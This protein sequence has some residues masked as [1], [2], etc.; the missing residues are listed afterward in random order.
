MVRGGEDGE[1]EGDGGEEGDA[2]S[3]LKGSSSRSHSPNGRGV[4]A[5]G[6]DRRPPSLY[7]ARSSK[8]GWGV[9]D[10]D[11][12]FRLGG[13]EKGV[14]V[15]GV[16]RAAKKASSS[17]LSP[18]ELRESRG[19]QRRRRRCHC[20]CQNRRRE[21]AAPGGRG[22]EGR[23]GEA[24]ERGEEVP[25]REEEEEEGGGGG[26]GG[27][28]SAAASAVAAYHPHCRMGGAVHGFMGPP[29]RLAATM[30]TAASAKGPAAI[31]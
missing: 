5:G 2:T 7:V 13:Y 14:V 30:A 29:P 20:R 15:K 1:K 21:A 26:G 24:E 25:R 6:R 19:P 17:S 3:V 22:L 27:G 16:A 4:R 31:F 23:R 8:S 12:A 10:G 9:D 18:S 28:T 11:V